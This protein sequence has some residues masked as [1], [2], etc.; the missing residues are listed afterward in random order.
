MQIILW[1]KLAVYL[2]LLFWIVKYWIATERKY[3]EELVRNYKHGEPYG[4]ALWKN[5][6][7]IVIDGTRAEMRG[8]PLKEIPFATVPYPKWVIERAEKEGP[9]HCYM[10]KVWE[11]IG[12]AE[13]AM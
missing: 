5:F 8:D 11:K 7:A 1:A 10:C 6:K 2:L 12:E 13:K 9:C 4:F 3:K